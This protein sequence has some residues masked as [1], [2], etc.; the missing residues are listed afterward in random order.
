[1]KLEDEP[2]PEYWMDRALAAEEKLAQLL[3]LDSITTDGTCPICGKPGTA[4]PQPATGD[5]RQ[6]KG[7]HCG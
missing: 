2:N 3:R 5:W 4:T 6:D 1:M 7:S